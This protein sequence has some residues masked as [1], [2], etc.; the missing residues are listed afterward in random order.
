M[1]ATSAF[2]QFHIGRALPHRKGSSCVVA[3]Y[4]ASDTSGVYAY[5]R[6]CGCECVRQCVNVKEYVSVWVGE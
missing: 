1:R 5:E 6:V 4:K 2:K 3:E